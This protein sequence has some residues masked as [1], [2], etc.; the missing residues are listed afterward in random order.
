MGQRGRW[1]SS[2]ENDIAGVVILSFKKTEAGILLSAA[3][4]GEM[5]L[6]G[7]TARV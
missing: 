5:T 3:S 4:G 1:A 6:A 2:P 7:W